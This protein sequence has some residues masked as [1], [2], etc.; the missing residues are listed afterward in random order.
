MASSP[1]TPSRA[2]RR[3]RRIDMR[4]VVG[5]LLMLATTLGSLAFWTAISDARPVVVATHDLPALAVLTPSDLT[6]AHVRMDDTLYQAAIPGDDLNTLVGKPLSQPVYAQEVLVRP[7]IAPRPALA[8]DQVAMTI[9]ITPET[10]VGGR[11]RPGDQ[12][13]VLVTLNKGKPDVRSA[14]VL[15]RVTVYDV[16]YE[17]R[18]GAINTDSITGSGAQGTARWLTLA[19]TAEQSRQLA[20][21]KGSGDLDVTLL[22]PRR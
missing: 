8:A 22:P 13:Q 18:V 4:I 12:V 21:A 6:V 1:L 17:Q 5:V 14:V 19:V 11:L 16:G 15:D 10:G 2:L 20:E 7:H 9:A 3:P